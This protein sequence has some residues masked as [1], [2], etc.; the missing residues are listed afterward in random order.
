MCEER[1][2][3]Y[4]ERRI[5]DGAVCQWSGTQP[6]SSFH[7]KPGGFIKQKLYGILSVRNPL[8]SNL[9]VAPSKY[10]ISKIN[11]GGGTLYNYVVYRYAE[12]T[13]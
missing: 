3:G 1:G 12:E 6:A 2:G 4:R 8:R 5:E 10:L 11:V 7:K 13:L 9:I